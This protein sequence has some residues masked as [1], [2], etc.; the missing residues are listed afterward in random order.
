[1]SLYV[2]ESIRVDFSPNYKSFSA[3]VDH[4]PF[5]YDLM[6]E[7]K[8]KLFIELGSWQ[9]FS[10]FVFCQSVKS[11]SLDTVCHAVDTWTGDEHS[12]ELVEKTYNDISQHARDHYRGFSY[13]LKTTFIE[14]SRQFSDESIGLLHIDGLH[15]YDAV[16]EDFE[17]WYPKVEPGGIILFHD[18][19]GRRNDFGVW[20]YWE[21]IT[22][23]HDTFSFHHGHGLGVLRK[24]GGDRSNDG[25]LIRHMFSAD[26]DDQQSLREL[27]NFAGQYLIALPQ[28]LKFREIRGRA[29][30]NLV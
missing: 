10:F 5:G 11:H 28:A 27:Y 24:N 4:A 6:A 26:P 20:K 25:P 15:T 21:E 14:A 2:P 22:G 8:P 30:K 17:T 16:K 19:A 7:V 12:G 1:M 29:D 23:E 13:L 18:I 9:G 3:W